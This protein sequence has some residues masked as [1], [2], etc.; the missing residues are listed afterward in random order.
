MSDCEYACYR[1]RIRRLEKELRREKPA[2]GLWEKAQFP[3]SG[4]SA[5]RCSV[6]HT[7]WETKT[8][9]CPHCGVKMGG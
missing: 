3:F 8:N 7:T 1:R 6:C 4:I 5:Y 9:Y 2:E